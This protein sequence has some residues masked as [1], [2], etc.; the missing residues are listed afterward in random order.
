VFDGFAPAERPEGAVRRI[1]VTVGVN[2]YGFG[3]LVR[4]VHRA[5]PAGAEI[6]WQ[7]GTTEV[8]GLDIAARGTVPTEELAQAMAAADVVVAHAGVGS[9]LMAIQA[10]RC[11]VL[12]PR[13]RAHREHADDHQRD[14]AGRLAGAGLALTCGPDA[15]DRALLVGAARRR[16]VRNEHARPFVLNTN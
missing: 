11:P 14:V 8:G 3:R 16:V 5:A 7:T 15:L 13:E 10:G 9:A 1:V 2:G 4:A 12:V 6:L